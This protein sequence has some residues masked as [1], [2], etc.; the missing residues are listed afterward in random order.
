MKISFGRD[1]VAWMGHPCHIALTK[2]SFSLTH[3]YGF[4]INLLKF[5]VPWN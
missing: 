5:S 2:T 1:D 3:V 4:K